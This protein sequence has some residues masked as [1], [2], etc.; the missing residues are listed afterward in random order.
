M[1]S[2]LSQSPFVLLASDALPSSELELLL[3][4]LS[5]GVI[6]L[7]DQ[8]MV[9]LC[10]PMA[11]RMLGLR[12]VDLLRKHFR[13]TVHHPML[14]QLLSSLQPIPPAIVQGEISVRL[15]NEDRLLK[16]AMH[17]LSPTAHGRIRRIIYLNDITEAAR[18]ARMKADFVAN[19]S[20]ELRTPLST[21]KA[22]TETLLESADRF[23]A[24]D[25]RFLEVLNKSVNRL[26]ELVHDLLDLNWVESP[27]L[28]IQLELIKLSELLNQIQLDVAGRL[29]AKQLQLVTDFTLTD[30]STDRKLLKLILMNLVDNAIKFTPHENGRIILRSR[31]EQDAAVLEVEDNGCGIPP[32]DIERVFERFYQV[33]KSRSEGAALG[34]G[35]GLAIVKHSVLAL[36][37]LVQLEST[38]NVGTLVRLRIPQRL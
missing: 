10:N 12:N 32:Q 16:V 27:N 14:H 13:N 38:L 1:E 23:T 30:V 34:T 17:H 20:H 26:E 18:S 28:S 8:D 31:R 22:A 35:L 11:A 24:S 2:S 37:G 33:D 25:R 21:M 29:A 36:G 3:L 7:D 9:C 19:A 5:E 6:A 15:N 4:H